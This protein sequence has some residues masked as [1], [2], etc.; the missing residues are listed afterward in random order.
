ML[1]FRLFSKIQFS[2]LAGIKNDLSS[3][4]E[5]RG[6][7]GRS[8]KFLVEIEILNETKDSTNTELYSQKPLRNFHGLNARLGSPNVF[9]IVFLYAKRAKNR[10]K[11]VCIHEITVRLPW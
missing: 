4:L 8:V 10:V 6:G 11:K 5:R 1:I 9:T 3:G 7:V 2:K